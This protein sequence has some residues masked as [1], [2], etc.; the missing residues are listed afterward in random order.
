MICEIQN[1]VKTYPSPSGLVQLV[2]LDD[3]SLSLDKGESVAI[4]GPSGS[5]KTTLLHIAAGLDSPDSGSVLIDGND[6]SKLGEKELAFMRNR[7]VGVVFQRDYL[8]PQ[9][10]LLENVLV[11]TLPYQNRRE[12]DLLRQRAM[13]ILERL[14]LSGRLDHTPSQL[15]GGERQRA[16]L[17]RALINCP[18]LLCAD[19]PTGS[20]DRDSAAEMGALLREINREEQTALILVT[21]SEKLAAEMDRTLVLNGGKIKTQGLISD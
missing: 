12:G 14:G 13:N 7:K 19:E 6:I 1:I 18:S 21:H 9:C 8:L 15:S 16:A 20:L 4:V 17:A 3:I 5:G 11:P 10:T 2:I